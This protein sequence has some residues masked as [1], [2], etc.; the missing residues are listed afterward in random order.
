MTSWNGLTATLSG[1]GVLRAH[2]DTGSLGRYSNRFAEN[3]ADFAAHPAA[4]RRGAAESKQQYAHADRF[5]AL[6]TYELR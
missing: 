2:P 6:S 5:T 1:S 4:A 3:I